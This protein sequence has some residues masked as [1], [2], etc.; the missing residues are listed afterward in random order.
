MPAIYLPLKCCYFDL[1]FKIRDLKLEIKY[2]MPLIYLQ[3]NNEMIIMRYDR[4][5]YERLSRYEYKIVVISF[6]F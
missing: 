5:L 3:L 4:F 6:V 2:M 1:K